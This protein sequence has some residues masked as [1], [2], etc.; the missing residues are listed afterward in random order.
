[1]DCACRDSFF[2]T[3]LLSLG[4]QQARNEQILAF[5]SYVNLYVYFFSLGQ[6]KKKN[7]SIRNCWFHYLVLPFLH[8]TTVPLSKHPSRR[9]TNSAIVQATARPRA[10]SAPL[11]CTVQKAQPA[12]STCPGK[13]FSVAGFSVFAYPVAEKP[14]QRLSA[15]TGESRTPGLWC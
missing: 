1:M 7:Q 13:S 11:P 6:K 14:L 15:P 12:R 10:G 2:L 5:W 3:P 4:W 9:T 8:L